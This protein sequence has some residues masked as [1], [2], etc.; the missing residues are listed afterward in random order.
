MLK[1]FLN[2]VTKQQLDRL[3]ERLRMD[4]DTLATSYVLQGIRNARFQI[5]F[6]VGACLLTAFLSSLGIWLLS[7]SMPLT[8]VAPNYL[9]WTRVAFLLFVPWPITILLGLWIVARS[10]ATVTLL[11]G[12]SGFIRKVKLFGTEIELNE[13]TK[14]KIQSAASEIDAALCE[15]KERV[16]KELSRIIARYQVEQKLSKFVDSAE[17][18]ASLRDAMTRSDVL[19]ILLIRS[20]TAGYISFLTTTLQ[21]LDM[22]AHFPIDT[23]SSER[24]GV[25]KP[26]FGLMTF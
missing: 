13:Q 8:T 24:F 14:Q 21:E 22:R 15:Y 17:M 12:L 4:A 7:V 6:Y 5:V 3:A 2:D 19:F 18:K 1:I 25:S 11:L 26:R 23:G 16:D 20:A 10:E 9:H